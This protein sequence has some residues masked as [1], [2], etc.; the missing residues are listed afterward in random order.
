MGV[1]T[2]ITSDSTS[3]IINSTYDFELGFVQLINNFLT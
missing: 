2:T 1:N 3:L